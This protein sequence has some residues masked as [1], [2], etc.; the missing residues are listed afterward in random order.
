MKLCWLVADDRGGG[1]VSVALSCV[2]QAQAAGHDATLL[3]LLPSTGWLAGQTGIRIDSLQKSDFDRDSPEAILNWL[4]THRPDAVV[5]NGCGQA[6]VV[7]SYIPATIRCI[8]T[9]HDTAPIYWRNAMEAQDDL[10]AIVAVSQTVAGKFASQVRVTHKLRVVP[11]GSVFPPPPDLGAPRADD[12]I[13]LGGDN[14]TKGAYDVLRLWPRLLDRGFTGRLHWL[15]LQHATFRRKV[16][17]LPQAAGRI[18]CC[19]RAPRE[20]VFAAAAQSKVHLMLSRVEPFG[21]VTIEAMSM[22]CVPVAWD[23]DTG[24]KEIVPPGAHFFSPLGDDDHLAGQVLLACAA[25][26]E[27][28]PVET[29]RAREHFSEEAM[30]TRGYAPLLDS[31]NRQSPRAARSREGQPVPEYVAPRGRLQVLPKWVRDAVRTLLGS[32]PRLGYWLRDLRGW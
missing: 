5:I 30:W 11:N 22:G 27:M 19:G 14:P 10:D 1:I 13:F 6:D 25:H 31:L 24:T 17:A 20:T 26:A 4:E 28:A 32:S 8:Y 21:M 2:R 29:R 18:L 15:G 7:L 3:L 16:E 23:I 12:L 9:V